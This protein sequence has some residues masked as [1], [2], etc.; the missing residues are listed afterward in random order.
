MIYE[1]ACTQVQK[2]VCISIYIYKKNKKGEW[3]NGKRQ[4]RGKQIWA[5]GARFDGDFY[6]DM[7]HG[8]GI[9]RAFYIYVYI[10]ECFIYIYIYMYVM[11][12]YQYTYLVV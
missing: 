5:S 7:M 9:L 3:M 11:Y 2:C 12:I 10:Y 8:Q 4:G 6:N 1:Y